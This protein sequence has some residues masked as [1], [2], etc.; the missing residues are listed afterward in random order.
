[1]K[2]NEKNGKVDYQSALKYL[3]INQESYS[4]Y[5]NSVR[6]KWQ[7]RNK[8]QFRKANGSKIEIDA[9]S[10]YLNGENITSFIGGGNKSTRF[11]QNNRTL[12]IPGEND[13]LQDEKE[14]L[15]N[16]SRA[17]SVTN[18]AKSNLGKTL[19]SINKS[20]DE[21]SN[22]SKPSMGI[23]NISQMDELQLFSKVL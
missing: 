10:S 19:K 22:I 14:T 7:V 3:F 15:T 4:F 12:I 2:S 16:R 1:M 20:P 17:L 21:K 8:S 5:I 18:Y 11:P 6:G 23:S 13:Y 9:S